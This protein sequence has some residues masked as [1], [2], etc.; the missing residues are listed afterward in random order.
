M[1]TALITGALVGLGLWC[2]AVGARLRRPSLA[3]VITNLDGIP[4]ARSGHAFLAD[5]AA[6][7]PLTPHRAA[8]ANLRLLGRDPASW[9]SERLVVGVLAGAAGLLW[10][11]VVG[12]TLALPLWV[13]LAFVLTLAAAGTALPIMTLRSQADARRAEL[14]IAL[15][16]YLDLVAVALSAGAGV[17]EAMADAAAIGTGPGFNEISDA[18]TSARRAGQPPWLALE[19]LAHELGI[20]ELRDLASTLALVGTEGARARE[21]LLARARGLRRDQITAAEAAAARRTEAAYIPVGLQFVGF[22]VL[23]VYPALLRVAQGLS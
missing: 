15:G 3:T 16:A 7:L 11:T 19:H 20:G 5:I 8:E 10:A 13:R 23:I 1:I 4:P 14:R 9:T 17:E 12:S 6:A 2:V 22:L 21:T 18:L